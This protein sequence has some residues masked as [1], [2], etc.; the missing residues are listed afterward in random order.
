AALAAQS[1]LPSLQSAAAAMLAM[2]G[3]N[4][5]AEIVRL[6]KVMTDEVGPLRTRTGLEHAAAHIAQLAPACEHLPVPR[7]ALDAASMDLHDLR[8]MRLVAECIT[9]AAL[10]RSES[11][12]AHQRADF[13]APSDAWQRHQALRFTRE[14]L[15]VA[16]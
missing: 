16:S 5:A 9:R 15:R 4:A 8:N 6:Q 14:G 11:R 3:I 7:G 13:P 12:G 2:P 10:E 1:A